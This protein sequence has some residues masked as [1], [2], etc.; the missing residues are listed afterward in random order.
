MPL[1]DPTRMRE[2][3]V[4][5]VVDVA[6]WSTGKLVGQGLFMFAVATL[7]ALPAIGFLFP[8]LAA[9]YLPE[10]AWGLEDE[11]PWAV[12]GFG[13]LLA[14]VAWFG[15]MAAIHCA[16]TLFDGNF[17]LRAGAGGV[18]FRLPGPFNLWTLGLTSK[19][20]QADLPWRDI[21][22][23]TITGE[24]N[25]GAIG[26]S[27][28][29]YDE[30]ILFETHSGPVYYVMTNCFTESTKIIARKIMDATEEPMSLPD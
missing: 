6:T 5:P 18:S 1:L 27:S 10:R 3:P 16:S 21:K 22:R 26:N 9:E 12:R 23:W 7:F 4:G 25:F 8:S 29:R 20:S 11:D 2:S 28:T 19:R 15:Y 17:F 30:S 14:F 24:K 13:G